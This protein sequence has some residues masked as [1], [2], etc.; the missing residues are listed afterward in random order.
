MG[1][2]HP[3]LCETPRSHLQLLIDR[4]WGNER[5]EDYRTFW[6]EANDLSYRPYADHAQWPVMRIDVQLAQM[7]LSQAMAVV[8]K[9][10]AGD[11]ERRVHLPC[12]TE[13]QAKRSLRQLLERNAEL[14]TRAAETLSI[15][16][17]LDACE[18]S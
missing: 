3:L 9:H 13:I 7:D 17:V 15:I 16:H 12:M 11:S 8:A 14:L 2:R 18:L 6:N 5:L 4:I 10:C 1:T